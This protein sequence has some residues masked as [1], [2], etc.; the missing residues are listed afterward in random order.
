MRN[1]K[2]LNRGRIAPESLTFPDLELIDAIFDPVF[3]T[4]LVALGSQGAQVMEVQQLMKDGLALVLA[5]FPTECATL[6]ALAHSPD[7]AELTFVFANGDIVLAKYDASAPNYDTTTT[8]IVGLIDC[9]L[10]AAAWSTDEETLALVSNDSNLL[11]LSKSFEPIAEKR[12]DPSDVAHTDNKHVSVG[13]GKEETQF[14]GRGFK[15]MERERLA[16][17]HAGLDLKEDSPLRDPTVAQIQKGTLLSEDDRSVKISWRGDSEYFVV[18]TIEEPP[19]TS[20][21]RRVLRVFSREGVLD[22][23]SEAVNGLEHNLSWRPSG[24]LIAT[25]QRTIDEDGDSILQLSFFE[26][27]GLRH[28]EFNTRLNPFEENIDSLAWSS[29]SEVLAMKLRNRVLLWT[30]KNYHWYLKQELCVDMGIPDNTVSFV[31][32]HPEKPLQLM[33]GT[34]LGGLLMF[35]F[36]ASIAS[37]PSVAGLDVGMNAVIDGYELKV[38]PLAIANVPPPIAY[39]DFEVSVPITDVSIGKSND[40]FAVV[41]SDHN[42]HVIK[43]SL[44]DLQ[45]HL[46]PKI[47]CIEKFQFATNTDLVKQVC[48]FE[49]DI[50]AVLIDTMLASAVV[51][52]N[53]A[54]PHMPMAVC[55]LDK[56]AVLIKSVSDSSA[57]VVECIDGS[58]Y[59]ITSSGEMKYLSQFPTLC[60]DFEVSKDADEFGD[61]KVFGLSSGGKLFCGEVQLTTGVT[62]FKVTENLL[63]FTNAHAQLFFIHLSAATSAVG[64]DFIQTA[65]SSSDER[66]RQIER[67]SILV[68]CIPSKYSVV[69][70]APRGNLETI[71]PRIMVLSGVRQFISKLEYLKAFV[72]C[73]THRIDLDILYDFDKEAFE[74]NAELFVQQINRIDY[75]D[76]FV[77]CLHQEDVS[78][79]KYRDTLLAE[80]VTVA[81]PKMEALSLKENQSLHSK[82][83]IINKEVSVVSSK[84]NKVCEIILNVLQKP[85]FDETFLQNRVTAF[86]CQS[87]PNLKGAL[88]LI[89]SLG[90]NER[91]DSMITHLCFLL[92]VNKLY[93]H[94]LELYDIKMA[95]N[96]AQKSQK[97]PKEYLPFL[98]NLHVQE[99]LQK[100]FLVDDYLKHNDK[101]L[102]WLADMGN[103]ASERFYKYVVEHSLYKNALAICKY[104]EEKTNQVYGLYADFLYD[105]KNF[106]EAGLIYE[107]LGIHESALDSFISCKRWKEA[108]SIV[109]GLQDQELILNTAQTL[110]STLKDAHQYVDAAEVTIKILKNVEEAVLLYCKGFKFDSAILLANEQNQPQLLE[111]VVDAQLGEGFG[112]IAEL[113]ADCSSQSLSQLKRLR[114][115]REKKESDPYAF[116]GT[117]QD[118]LDTPDN[119]SVAASETSTTPSFFTKYTGKT[120]GT[121]KTG[122]SR[123]TSKNRKREERKRAK[124]RKGTVYEEEYLIKSIGRLIERLDQTEDDAVSLIEG[125]IRRR[126]LHQAY[127]LQQSWTTL[128]QFLKD[129]IV[130]IHNMSERDR[131]RLDDDGNVYLIEEIPVPTIKDFKK[132]QI[133]DF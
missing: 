55:E 21:F 1:L 58:V 47:S 125:L 100:Q 84:I 75:L 126:K 90:E 29:N 112:T 3:D 30:T 51:L 40:I 17:L 120:A 66:V 122:A 110:A 33:V 52:F 108:I 64:F 99:P 76:L 105:E 124:G 37:G 117:L 121:A 95:L 89:S 42:V 25:T 12:L 73:R 53:T 114:E 62:S 15:A 4:V 127:Q 28:G 2:L 26:R 49:D 78:R 68:S 93:N 27:N 106:A 81:A 39:A 18:S 16:I 65:D 5:S 7:M 92:D 38:T 128:V 44:S 91:Q 59:E 82:K 119:V 102:Q 46:E 14:K 133:L 77:S 86:A 43:S 71:C 116:Y 70:Q 57:A 107:S 74:K 20:D 103:T 97:D 96:I 35:N 32:F 24:A 63:A 8:E 130:E 87:P 69:L 88:E 132:L 118:D 9:G 36:A 22:S 45:E 101:A 23:V 56:R 31:K 41:T 131:E 67:G 94:A 85:P 50:V 123:K 115:L 48:V 19:A 60:V 6:L 104:D 61:A 98:Q 11:V 83:M 79:T 129:N 109:T 13:W 34:S 80:G 10:R 113:L 72:A 111:L 54:D